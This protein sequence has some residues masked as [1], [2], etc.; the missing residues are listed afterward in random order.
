MVS[1]EDGRAWPLGMRQMRRVLLKTHQCLADS[2][3]NYSP[4]R[5]KQAKV[6]SRFI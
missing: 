2:R 3:I 1:K 4:R 6:L 5:G